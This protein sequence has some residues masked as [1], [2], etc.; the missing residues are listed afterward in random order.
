MADKF[1]NSHA[2]AKKAEARVNDIF[3]LKQS[4]SKGLRHFLTRFN[5]V[6]MTLPNVLEGMVVATFQNGLNRN[7]SRAIGKLLRRL[8]KYPPTTWDDIHDTYCA[9]VR[10]NK[11]D[12]NGPT[13]QL[14]SVQIESRKDRRN[15]NKRDHAGP[16]PNRERHQPYVKVAVVP[17]PYHG[18]GPPRPQTGTHQSERVCKEVEKL[19]VNG[20]IRESK[21][22]QWVANVVIVKKKNGKWRMCVDLTNLNKA[23]PKDSFPLPY[24]D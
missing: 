23:C 10:A 15:D 9:E 3:A 24:I 21:Y 13:Q 12:L 4:P 8:M 5:R 2:R 6:R 16:R 1:V 20:S 22:P 18:D 19:L 7:G 11:D 17:P 14:T